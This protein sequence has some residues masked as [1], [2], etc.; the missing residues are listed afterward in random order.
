LLSPCTV[1]GGFGLGLKP[2]TV[3]S[4]GFRREDVVL[5]AP[6]GLTTILYPQIRELEVGGRGAMQEG[7][8]FIGGGF[9]L[10]GAAAGM[11]VASALNGLTSRT[12]VET[13]VN[14]R[15]ENWG[16][17]VHYG[18]QT[19]EQLR[20]SLT[21]PLAKVADQRRETPAAQSR[22]AAAQLSEVGELHSSGILTDEEFAAAKARILGQP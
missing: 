5:A 16:V 10:E 22:D 13:L 6:T 11:L 8:G 3:I 12:Q 7:G 17:I 1:V 2:G 21:G 15:T 9:G 19:P 20:I 18:Q 4:F 14:L